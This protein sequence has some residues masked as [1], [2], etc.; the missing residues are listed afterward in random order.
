[1]RS[2]YSASQ[3]NYLNLYCFLLFIMFVL[4]GFALL[5]Q[6]KTSAHENESVSPPQQVAGRIFIVNTTN[7]GVDVAPGDGLC[8]T[9]INTPG[10]Q[11]SLRAAIIEA[12]ASPGDDAIRFELPPSDPGCHMI[13]NQ[14]V[15][16]FSNALPDIS[17]NIEFDGPGAKLLQ[18][19]PT[20][21]RG[22]R[23]TSFGTVT[24]SSLTINGGFAAGT[25]VGG[26]ILNLNGGT[27]N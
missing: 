19:L 4:V 14:C 8:D 6:H 11:C 10:E 9:D 1:M 26:D 3:H 20:S 2:S 5:A 7:D 12:N 13:S 25:G 16:R 23:I 21:V 15:I 18:I 24:F 22:F 27:V 17:S